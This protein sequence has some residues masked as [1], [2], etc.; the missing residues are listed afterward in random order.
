MHCLSKRTQDLMFCKPATSHGYNH[1]TIVQFFLPSPHRITWRTRISVSDYRSHRLAAL[2]WW[3]HLA[4]KKVNLEVSARPTLWGHSV[5]EMPT[6]CR[7][8]LTPRGRRFVIW[9]KFLFQSLR[10]CLLSIKRWNCN[11]RHFL[12]GQPSSPRT[13]ALGHW[14]ISKIEHNASRCLENILSHL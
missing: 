2:C 10:P 5:F 3:R 14:Q 8:I 11:L 13:H 9:N 12:S 4:A 1:P 7:T 6:N